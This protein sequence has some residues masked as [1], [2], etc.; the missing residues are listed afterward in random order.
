M[1]RRKA[2]RKS[3]KIQPSPL[4]LWFLM[5]SW[6]G[7]STQSAQHYVDISQSAS[8]VSRR[9]LRQG[10]NWAVSGVTVHIPTLATG[11][12]WHPAN[13]SISVNSLHNTWVQAQSW[14]KSFDAWM[15]MNREALEETESVKGKFLDFK[16]YADANHHNKGFVGNLLPAHYTAG[17]W[18]PSTVHVPRGQAAPGETLEREFIALGASY[19]GTS[20]TTGFNAVSL[21]QGYSASRGLPLISDP[22]TPSDITDADGNFPENWMTAMR[23]DGIDQSSEVIEDIVA[24]DQPPYPFENDGVS[25]Q[26]MYPGGETQNPFMYPVDTIEFTSNNLSGRVKLSGSN[27][28]CGLMRIDNLLRAVGPDGATV[29]EYMIVELNLIPGEHKGYLAQP[30]SEM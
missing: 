10:L 27:Y 24:Y 17:E 28:P 13:R 25:T 2:K 20:P 12:T 30:M 16:I 9:F 6:D 15:R 23:N 11:N 21:I 22:N 26:T 8:L 7:T 14:R 29:Q 4:K 18:I 5:P 1:A 19:P 3:N